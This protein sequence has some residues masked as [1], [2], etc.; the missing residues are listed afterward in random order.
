MEKKTVR[1]KKV[2]KKKIKKDVVKK[3]PSKKTTHKKS[4]EDEK[5]LT[6]KTLTKKTTVKKE[7]TKKI[8]D[9]NPVNKINTKV[10]EIKEEYDFDRLKCYLRDDCHI[11]KNLLEKKRKSIYQKI[12]ISIASYR[13]PELIPTI[14]NC[15][16]NA[17]YPENIVFGICLQEG[18]AIN[19][20]FPRSNKDKF[21]VIRMKY[22]EAKGVCYAR[23]LIQ[24][25]LVRD[26]TY[27]LQIDSHMRFVPNWD[28]KLIDCLQ[29]CESLKPILSV[30]VGVYKPGQNDYL[31]NKQPCI[32]TAPNFQAN[33][34]NLNKQP[35]YIN[36]RKLPIYSYLGSGHFF[37]TYMKWCEECPYP[38]KKI[39]F[40]G[41]EDVI[42]I[43]SFYQGWDIFAPNKAFIYH[44]Y[45]RDGENKI[46]ETINTDN[47]NKGLH[48]DYKKVKL[49]TKYENVKNR[50]FDKYCRLTGINYKTGKINDIA[51]SGEFPIKDLYNLNNYRITKY[52]CNNDIRFEKRANNVWHEYK[53]GELEYAYKCIYSKNK[54]NYL[55]DYDRKFHIKVNSNSINMLKD[56]QWIKLY[57]IHK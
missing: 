56:D 42:S 45:G 4:K 26:E 40:W 16:D 35:I 47:K 13:D 53:N 27:F 51:K 41:E 50:T 46:W 15:L 32:L 22:S 9:E 48:P 31:E 37:F 6:D 36:E 33:T 55:Y 20:K 38:D 29:M 1:K 24:K 54:E 21:R 14:L 23:N 52:H 25:K 44:Y 39:L 49:F 3:K 34:L 10:E 11:N 28:K 8:I 12:F 57:D 43:K 19:K 7:T 18:D 17:R 30:Y 2:V 5:I